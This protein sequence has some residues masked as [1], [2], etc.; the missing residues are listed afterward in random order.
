MKKSVLALGLAGCLQLPVHA[1]KSVAN[2]LPQRLF[3][4]GKEMFVDQ[5][6]VGTIHRMEEFKK[7]SKD[8]DQ[9]EEA[10][11]LIIS[12]F[13]YQGNPNVL[14]Q[15]KDFLEN[16]PET[17]HRQE[18]A[19]FIGSIHFE[20]KEW[21]KA[22][23]WLSQ[24]DLDYLSPSQQEDCSFRLAYS[25]LQAKKYDESYRLFGLL[26][27]KSKKYDEDAN[28]YK[29][30]I[31]FQQKRY[32]QSTPVFEKLTRSSKYKELASFY[33]LQTDFAEDKS[34]EAITNGEAFLQDYQ[35]SAYK[36]EVYRILGNSYYRKGIMVNSI[37][38]Y[39]NYLKSTDKPFREDMLYLGS[40]YLGI[41]NYPKAIECL[42]QATSYSDIIGQEAYMQL[43]IASEKQGN[44][45]DALLAFQAASKMNYSKDLSEKSLYNYAILLYRS[46][47][48]V[49][50]QSI[51]VFQQ[52]LEQY[53]NSKYSDNINEAFASTLLS[54]KNYPAAL[55]AI[56]KIKSPD[57]KIFEAKQMILLQLGIQNY[58]NGA[59]N[60]A[61]QRFNETIALGSY[62]I[63][64]R[65]QAYFWR[66]ESFYK[67][68]N[69]TASARDYEAFISQASSDEDNYNI[70]R[71][72]L[73]Y[74][75]FKLNQYSKANT[76]FLSYVDLENNKL[77][78]SY[79]DALNRIGDGYLFARNY[80][81]ANR[82]YGRA[83]N[84]N[85][86]NADYSEFQKAFVLG[87]Q[88]DY[89]GKISALD[90]LMAKYPQSQYYDDALYEKSRA[91]AM[92]DRENE[93]IPVLEK[94]LSNYP[95]SLLAQKGGV[96][97]GQMYYNTNQPQKAIQ[98]Y[99]NVVKD[100]PETEEAHIAVQSMEGIYKDIN[101]IDSY[102]SYVNSLGTGMRISSSRQDS[103][104]Y[105]AAENIYLKGQ[106]NQA[107]E[108]FNKYLQT[109][110]KGY[111]SGDAHYYLGVIS[112][113][114]KD[115]INALNEFRQTI[116]GGNSRF[117]E[118]ALS[119]AADI[120]F[121]N[122]NY[123]VAYQYYNRLGTMTLKAETKDAAQIG[124]LRCAAYDNRD[125]EVIISA[126]KI[127]GQS[128]TTPEILKEAYFYRGKAYLNL[129]E[130]EKGIADLRQ[131]A[132][133]P[134]YIQ[135]A[136]AQFILADTFYKWKSY[137]KAIAQVNE[138]LK[139]GTP[140]EYWMAR[141][142]IVLSDSYAAKGDKFSAKQY[143]ESLKDNYKGGETDITEMI[144]SRLSKMN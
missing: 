64:A 132:T 103:L 99:K 97:L 124:M 141:A 34:N 80:S 42:K 125:Q 11:Y 85:P 79:S 102:A 39:E 108:S 118:E 72:D 43:G 24:A 71:Y 67:L 138:F 15:L 1:Q 14:N 86:Q 22:A 47:L 6:Y 44:N 106:K 35:N 29:A 104:T 33:L 123:T 127:I 133:D 115:N 105:L 112:F 48:G 56:N 89:N 110:P 117:T 16:H 68:A 63:K 31:D 114:K 82:Y 37:S 65:N 83:A 81:E 142:L 10:D 50:D 45:S 143:L 74:T 32:D 5:N 69:Y 75:Y 90:Q 95:G 119:A 19:F 52:F 88:R 57:K 144:S 40:A 96:Q 128:K 107:Q 30:Y 51:S 27:Q 20:N 61:I 2:E 136:E 38:N 28:Y 13:Y 41:K 59:T 70:A 126:T 137:D 139:K 60:D 122:K 129:K 109:F 46:S 62:N 120:E 94:L 25:D 17:Y 116:E 92:L 26:S 113:E 77:L 87:L 100:Y 66:G 12:S 53:P 111:Y 135:G 73:G 76:A 101:D 140:H 91:L 131:C 8:K 21:E 18:I 121:D 84:Q 55:S 49:F 3:L 98:A 4:Q 130:T 36:G 58:I 9:I 7:L 134:R 23:Y 93:A 78:S 54:T